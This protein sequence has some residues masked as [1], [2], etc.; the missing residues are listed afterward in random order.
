LG[1]VD[2]W[3]VWVTCPVERLWPGLRKNDMYSTPRFLEFLLSQ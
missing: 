2:V 3:E 1:L